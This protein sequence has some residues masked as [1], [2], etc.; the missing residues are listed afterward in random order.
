MADEGLIDF[1]KLAEKSSR[2]MKALDTDEVPDP[3][4]LYPLA[5]T[6]HRM[7]AALVQ[8]LSEQHSRA[9]ETMTELSQFALDDSEFGRKLL[10]VVWRLLTRLHER[11]V[12]SDDDAAHIV[13]AVDPFAEIEMWLMRFN[14]EDDPE[15]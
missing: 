4:Q 5:K 14:R 9:S 1:V 13:G 10:N 8:T 6:Q 12:I 7:I 15:T 3:T 11:G 2:L